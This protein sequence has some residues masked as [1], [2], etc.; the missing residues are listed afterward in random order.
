MSIVATSRAAKDVLTKKRHI[1]RANPDRDA[2]PSELAIG[3][4]KTIGERNA[5]ALRVA[6]EA[7]IREIAERFGLS[8]SV[9]SVRADD[10]GFIYQ[11][12]LD[13]ANAPNHPGQ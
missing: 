4:V 7:S 12:A 13:L 3:R 5:K 11:V 2:P 10:H 1:E 9:G 8:G 6:I